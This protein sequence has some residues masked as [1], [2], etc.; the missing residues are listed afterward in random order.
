MTVRHIPASP[1]AQSSDIVQQG[2]SKQLDRST[3]KKLEDL[4]FASDPF[5]KDFFIS[6]TKSDKAWAEWIAWTLEAAG[7]STVIQAW[8]FR[9]GSNFVLEM[10]RAANEAKR[11][12]A[13]LSQQ[14]LESTFTKPEW[15]AAF[16]QDP[17]GKKQKLIPVR[18]ATCEL[19][20]ILAP[21]VY[22]DLVSLP[23]NDARTALLGAFS[24]RAKPDSAPGFPGAQRPHVPPI[25]P[26]YPGTA[27]VTSGPVAEALLSKAT[28]S[29]S[30]GTPEGR[31]SAIQRLQFMQR[32]NALVPQQFNML[33][34]AVGPLPG[35]IPPM[36]APQGDRTAALLNWAEAPGGCGVSRLRELLEA[37]VDSSRSP[38]SSARG[39]LASPDVVSTPPDTTQETRIAPQAQETKA[40]QSPSVAN[41]E[42]RLKSS[43]AF[44]TVGDLRNAE[45]EVRESILGNCYSVDAHYMLARIIASDDARL[46]EARAECEEALKIDSDHLDTVELL[47]EINGKINDREKRE[48][49]DRAE[50]R[51]RHAD[52]VREKGE[53]LLAAKLYG[54]AALQLDVSYAEAHFRFG[55]ALAALRAFPRET[56]AAH[57]VLGMEYDLEHQIEGAYWT[58]TQLNPEY[59]EAHLA[60]AHE[61]K[62]PMWAVRSYLEA[63]RVRPDSTIAHFDL[64]KVL[65][66]LIS[67]GKLAEFRQVLCKPNS[68]EYSY[69]KQFERELEMLNDTD[70]LTEYQKAAALDPDS[71]T[72]VE[73]AKAL[74]RL[75]S[76]S[77]GIKSVAQSFMRKRT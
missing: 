30:Q 12:I 49:R 5:M 56:L 8:D 11:T 61:Q 23:E 4:I 28:E 35:L 47:G 55:A 25:Q 20:G 19:T 18:I 48:K 36:P 57:G 58:A 70:A 13:V 33:L 64:A 24:E 63:I 43:R 26:A 66:Q 77:W 37:I 68:S 2:A 46:T 41:P 15:A 71:P 10:Q 39:Q 22:L 54:E 21:I 45:T 74:E 40:V 72:R 53:L 62:D 59:F 67:R 31:L 38:A 51:L 16:A 32:L 9:P 42:G 76:K 27:N 75:G 14:Y 69:V 52:K 50:R 65:D 44:F 34:F 17:Q 29:A 73:I 6:Y 1:L 3:Q 7:Y 60:M